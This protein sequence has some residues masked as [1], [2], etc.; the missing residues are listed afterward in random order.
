MPALPCKKLAQCAAIAARGLS[1]SSLGAYCDQ[2][3]FARFLHRLLVP[4]SRGGNPHKLIAELSK[5]FGGL[6]HARFGRL[7][8]LRGTS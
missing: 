5:R 1:W 3:A 8:S 4:L 6:T 2:A 7:G